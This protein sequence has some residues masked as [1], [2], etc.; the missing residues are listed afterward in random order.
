[1]DIK[2]SVLLLWREKERREKERRE[3]ER[4]EKERREKERREKERSIDTLQ[5][6]KGKRL[7]S[8]VSIV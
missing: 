2:R 6:F 4:R 7:F 8:L 3:K 1:L 5:K